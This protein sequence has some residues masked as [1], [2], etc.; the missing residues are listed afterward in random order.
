MSPFPLACNQKF[1]MPVCLM[2]SRCAGIFPYPAR[3]GK[4]VTLQ[5]CLGT[6]YALYPWWVR[7]EV[8]WEQG[9][10]GDRG[11]TTFGTRRPRE[12]GRQ[13]PGKEGKGS[14]AQGGGLRIL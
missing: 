13:R 9:G 11:G 7:R 1:T 14:S 12:A 3:D 4:K 2:F 8:L 6:T 10:G 5:L